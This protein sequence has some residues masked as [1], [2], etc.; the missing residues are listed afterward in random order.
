MPLSPV[1]V[2][3]STPTKTRHYPTSRVEQPQRRRTHSTD[4][5]AS[6]I[7][8]PK[9]DRF[10]FLLE[11]ESE[12]GVKRRHSD[13]NKKISDPEKAL[14][15]KAAKQRALDK[16]T[17]RREKKWVNMIR[18][19]EKNK[20]KK[21]HQQ[22]ILSRVRKGIPDKLRG[23][24]WSLLGDVPNTIDFTKK[25]QYNELLLQAEM[26]GRGGRTDE[27]AL[28]QVRDT[29]ERD[30]KRTFPNHIMFKDLQEDRISEEEF[31]ELLVSP[32]NTFDK[33]ENEVAVV[34]YT[35]EEETPDLLNSAG[36]QA[37]LR[38]VLRAYSM[39][40]QETGYCQGM[41][42]IVAMFLTFM[43]EEEAFWLLVFIMNDQPCNMRN[44][45]GSDMSQSSQVL[46]V[47]SRLIEQFLP[48]LA[49]HLHR[50]NVHISMY[51][52][53]WLLT[54]YTT[55]FP[56][57]LVTRVWDCFLAEGWKIVYRIMLAI[58]SVH[59]RKLLKM[60]F[61]DILGFFR[62]VG[63]KAEADKLFE[64]AFKIQ[65]KNKHV[66]KYEKEYLLQEKEN[67]R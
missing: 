54:I 40:D 6:L 43:T 67:K 18:S 15:A 49:K 1:F 7:T 52:T 51:A 30:I 61:E 3:V 45:F 41:N 23:A 37:S 10:G 62:D 50:E 31:D 24:V 20:N 2:K 38:R 4:D 13:T 64:V 25:G 63:Q 8:K 34:I 46:H 11:N 55:K 12:H 29:I 32:T 28:V 56:F 22:R 21:K 14:V 42:F 48:K 66:K 17:K 35:K 60:D 65:L 57:E 9:T 36:G 59:E 58:L 47:G 5:L 26:V 53:H 16:V 44:M 39:Y 27:D 33:N 19:W